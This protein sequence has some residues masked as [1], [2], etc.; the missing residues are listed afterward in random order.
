MGSR[1]EQLTAFSYINTSGFPFESNLTVLPLFQMMVITYK[2]YKLVCLLNDT[3]VTH[4]IQH[5]MIGQYITMNWKGY[6]RKLS[7]PNLSYYTGISLEGL[8]KTMK[9]SVGIVGVLAKIRIEQFPKI[10]KAL[11]VQPSCLVI[12]EPLGSTTSKLW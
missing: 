5:Q 9:I 4:N 7:W 8:R 11:L 12:S 2:I 1:R 6:E 10:Q 3:V